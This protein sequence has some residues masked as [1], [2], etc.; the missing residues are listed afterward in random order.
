MKK[1]AWITLCFLYLIDLTNAQDWEAIR[2]DDKP[3]LVAQE[4]ELSIINTIWINSVTV[5][6]EDFLKIQPK[7]NQISSQILLIFN[8]EGQLAYQKTI[9]TLT[10]KRYTVAL[11]LPKGE[12][13]Y[14]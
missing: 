14:L 12:C 13:K 10:T 3:H 5:F 2:L 1:K 6:D 4:E 11:H 8:P 7:S 9:P